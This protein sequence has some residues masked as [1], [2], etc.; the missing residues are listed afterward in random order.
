MQELIQDFWNGGS[1][2]LYKGVGVP[3]A[4]SIPFS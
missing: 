3:F 1:F 2:K 4:D